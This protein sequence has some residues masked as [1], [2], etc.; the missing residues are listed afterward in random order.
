[1]LEKTKENINFEKAELLK[2]VFKMKAIFPYA[3]LV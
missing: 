3:K 2:A 1:M